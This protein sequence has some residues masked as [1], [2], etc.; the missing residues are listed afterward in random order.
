MKNHKQ[1]LF[2]YSDIGWIIILSIMIITMMIGCMSCGR[3]IKETTK[4]NTVVDSTAVKEK[5]SIIQVKESV[6]ARLQ[7][8]NR[9]LQYSG[10]VFD[11]INNYDTVCPERSVTIG[12]DGSITAKGPIKSANVTKDKHQKTI[13]DWER[14][15]DSLYQVKSKDST[16]VKTVTNTVTKYKDRGIPGWQWFLFAVALIAAFYAGHKRGYLFFG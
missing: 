3:V 8:E 6:I 13:A 10:V 9:E 1:K 7:N 16:T 12:A 4:T 2:P 5:D 15:Y 14:K 11:T